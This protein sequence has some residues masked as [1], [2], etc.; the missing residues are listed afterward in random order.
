MTLAELLQSR[1]RADLRH[2]GAAYIEAERVSLIRVTSENVF[3]VVV[4]GAEY[5]TQ[6]RYQPEDIS[7]FCTCEQFTKSKSCKHLWGTILAADQRGFVNPAI[8]PGRLLPFA[9]PALTQPL[10]ADDLDSGGPDPDGESRMP[11]GKAKA[12][13]PAPVRPTRPWEARLAELSGE[14][15]GTPEAR[16]GGDPEERQIFYEVDIEA[17]RESGK[18]VIQASQ[19]Q[20]RAGG[21]WGKIKPLKIRPG[22][23]DQIEHEDDR[24]FLSYLAG[25][26]PERT[27][28]S[29]QQAEL[30]TS[31]H[32]FQVPWE[33]GQLILP[34]M[35]RS[36]RLR[37]LGSDEAGQQHLS[38]DEGEP[39]ELT[40]RVRR[41]TE[42]EGWK[43]SGLL[44]RNDETLELSEVPLVIPGGFVVTSD[45][46][47]LLRDFGAPEWM[48]GL[49]AAGPLQIPLSD[50]HDFVDRLLDIP[51]L[52]RLD[53]PKELQLEEVRVQ[54]QPMLRISA[55]PMTRWRNDS[56]NAE[57][58][59]EYL[60]LPVSGSSARWAVVQRE[61]NRCIIRDRSFE[62]HCWERLRQ[63]GF[64]RRLGDLK[65][66]VNVEIARRDLGRA[67]R[68]LVEGGWN[69]FAD[70]S[71]VRQAGGLRFRVSSD[72]DWFDVHTEV[73]FEGRSVSFPELLRALERGDSTVRLDDGSL[74]ILPE[75]WLEQ[76][77]MISGLGTT[78]EDGLRFSTSQAAL[79]DAL[80][81]SQESVEI[82]AGFERM[83]ERFRNFSGL[84]QVE[85]P[86]TFVGQLRGYQREGLSW[87]KFLGDF[88][89]GGCL[90]DDMGLGKTVQ[91]LAML[92]RRLEDVKSPPPSLV[93]VPRSLM[94]N[95]SSEC[96]RF[97]PGLRVMEYTGLERANSRA[98]F[99]RH[100]LI[101]T[102]YGTVRRDIA[103]LKDIDFDYV[104]LDEAQTIKNPSS[105]IA[106]AS[107]LLKANFRLALSG[108]PIENNAGDLW[109]IFEFLNPGML[110]R[111][112]AFRTHIADPDSRESRE[113]V[114]KGLRPFILRRT[115]K[116]VAAE[117]PDRLEETIV[118]DMEPEQ[119]R[120]Y[121]ELRLH[122][123]DSLLGLVQ[124]QGIAKTR[125]HVLEALLRLRQAACH[126]ALLKRGDESEPYAKLDVLVPHLQELISEG[127]KALVFSQFTSMLSILRE[128]LDRQGIVY[129]Y[130][131]G[132]TRDRK[133][134]VEHFQDDP[135]CPV[136][137]ISLKAGGLGLNL[138]AADYVF[139][140]DPWWNPAVEAQAIDRA[141]RVGQTRTVF[142]YRLICRDT[143]E[144]KIAELQ[145]QKRELAD[146]ILAGD[147][148]S[149]VLKDLSVEDLELLF[150]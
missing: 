126:P 138:T 119:R 11:R 123:R 30:R 71:K 41:D 82:D 32:R 66:T 116:Q 124:E 129:E 40:I 85:V 43:V 101:L 4:D 52:P 112:T 143:V 69:V 63:T 10:T 92:L 70:G 29:T 55:P 131:D 144:E 136:F 49:T 94:F 96:G 104:V 44:V 97:A 1:F 87:L 79:L 84:E 64:R 80:L 88:N 120:L 14:M 28:W 48:R 5:Q 72:T 142:A 113:M 9:A 137:L 57:V 27:N 26:I 117:L 2:R 74:G 34:D 86:A 62:G 145:K 89:F 47:S 13:P 61:N 105:Q 141:H 90:A 106:R 134:R 139:L 91:F 109:S 147:D 21:Q 59:F 39:W 81:A 98:D 7:L 37:I 78:T 65:Q 38:W 58:I 95:W 132:K 53:L 42:A 31:A 103:V 146:A 54:P 149:N 46:I 121:D 127:H 150:S 6:L 133:A 130:L 75:E 35:C 122:Y 108:T 56:L 25:A 60:G 18:L 45:S 140:L 3:G 12:R 36:S 17:S 51:S 50:Q 93:V 102:T 16:G 99:S 135:A 73:D 20:R 67:V 33:L 19:R 111:S 115:K 24:T 118:C 83:R 100:H 107:R 114:A 15:N 110:G 128:H 76:I 22:E 148:S 77:G 68:E 125:M 8:R 23:L